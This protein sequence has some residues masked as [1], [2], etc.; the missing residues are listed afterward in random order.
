MRET[1]NS[2]HLPGSAGSG[3]HSLPKL[4]FLLC[5]VALVAMTGHQARQSHAQEKASDRYTVH[6]DVYSGRTN[7][8][9]TLTPQQ[10]ARVRELLVGLPLSTNGMQPPPALGYRGFI[11][12]TE[13][14]AGGVRISEGFVSK[15]PNGEM[16]R[17]G[18]TR[19]GGWSNTSYHCR[20][21]EI[22]ACAAIAVTIAL[23][24]K[25]FT[26]TSIL[27]GTLR[28]DDATFCWVVL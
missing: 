25:D 19:T 5:G 9:W 26:C 27:F 15:Y 10:S 28:R 6:L 18:S 21:C 20:R 24:P 23:G 11:V 16:G 2:P 13:P 1:S 12:E 7:P 3:G 17:S 14:P 8:M 4:F 22:M